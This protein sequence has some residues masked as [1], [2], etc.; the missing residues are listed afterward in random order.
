MNTPP[1]AP[2]AAAPEARP[3]KPRYDV[4]VLR[5]RALTPRMV[6]VTFGGEMLGGFEWNGPAAHIKLIFPTP[7]AAAAAGTSAAPAVRP[8]M[9]TYT[10]RRFDPRGPELDVDFV[11]HG[12]GPASSW[13]AQA[14]IGQRLTVAGPGRSYSIDREA[15]WYLL[16]GDDTAIPALGTILEGLPAHIPATVLAEVVDRREEHPLTAPRSHTSVRWLPRGPDPSAAGRPLEEA[17]R[18]LQLPPGSGRVYVACEASAMRRIRS[19]LLHERDLPKAHLVTR[20][21]WRLGETDHPDRDY[22]EDVA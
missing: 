9:R 15:D 2:G 19:H 14:A 4:E 10:P 17:L 21:Y 1:S 12:E 7:Q 13:A 5:I 8:T 20:G 11:I 22:G 6:R 3:R 18:G 16:V